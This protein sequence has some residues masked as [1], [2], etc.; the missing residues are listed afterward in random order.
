MRCMKYHTYIKYLIKSFFSN[1][2]S[3]NYYTVGNI[4]FLII[5]ILNYK[6]F[7]YAKVYL[8]K[9]RKNSEKQF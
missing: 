6:L 5:R 4:F 3:Q 7:E 2:Y 9:F 1:N 8:L